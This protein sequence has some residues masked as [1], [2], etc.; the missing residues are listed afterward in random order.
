[1]IVGTT[2]MR[3]EHISWF[4]FA[5]C[6]VCECWAR[7][8]LPSTWNGSAWHRSQWNLSGTNQTSPTLFS[9]HHNN[10]T[11]PMLIPMSFGCGSSCRWAAK[12]SVCPVPE[13]RVLDVWQTYRAVVRKKKRCALLARNQRYDSS[14]S[15]SPT[16][17]I[18]IRVD[19]VLFK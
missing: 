16:P 6:S 9:D 18:W 4:P 7:R 8:I 17:S 5:L 14:L 2:G 15:T 19:L 1:V 11:H 3:Q 10:F 12:N 13:R